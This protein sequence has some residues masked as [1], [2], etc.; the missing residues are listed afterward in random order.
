M[1][2]PDPDAVVRSLPARVHGRYLARWADRT[3][4]TAPLVVGFHGYAENAE[5]M[6]RALATL[7]GAD[8]WSLAAVQALHPFY[9]SRTGEVV[10]CW[11]TRQDRES[12]IADNIAYVADALREIRDEVGTEAP[13]FL[14][15]FSQGTAITYRAAARSG[16][17]CAG[18]VALAGD[19]PPE[20][21]EEDLSVLPPVLVGRGS[22]DAWYDEAKLEA[23]LELLRTGGVTVETCV[24]PGGHV[25]TDEFRAACAAFVT[26][27]AATRRRSPA[28]PPGPVLPGP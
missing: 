7:P 6:L 18:V 2:V 26:R 20:L 1:T 13:V 23:D 19:V 17:P 8:G 24:F 22:E 10:A 3:A 15:G 12:A 5:A 11:M 14:L 21:A 27:L 9:N 16:H 4:D 28:P 25:W